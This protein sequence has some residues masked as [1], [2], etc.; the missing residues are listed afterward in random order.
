MIQ[1][2]EHITAPEVILL[3]KQKH[4]GASSEAIV[5]GKFNCTL[6]DAKLRVDADVLRA[7]ILIDQACRRV[8]KKAKQLLICKPPLI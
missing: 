1:L 2:V 6:S 4:P 5:E 3:Y 7:K 8:D